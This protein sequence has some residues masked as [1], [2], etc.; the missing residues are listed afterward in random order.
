MAHNSAE[1]PEVKIAVSFR[2]QGR[3][4]FAKDFSSIVAKNLLCLPV[5]FNDY[6][7]LV[8]GKNSDWGVFV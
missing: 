5:E 7:L 8:Y 2:Y 6:F 1:G 3:H 4:M